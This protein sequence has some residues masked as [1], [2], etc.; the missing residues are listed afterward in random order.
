IDSVASRRAWALATNLNLDSVSCWWYRR[1]LV[2]RR[3]RLTIPKDTYE[4]D[5]GTP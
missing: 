4:L 5:V 3:V 2:S 1:K